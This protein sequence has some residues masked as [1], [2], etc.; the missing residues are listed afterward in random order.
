MNYERWSLP[1]RIEV[2]PAGLIVKHRRYDW[3]R[4]GQQ[5]KKKMIPWHEAQLFAIRSGK[6]GGATI[7]YELSSP[8]TVLTFDRILRPRWWSRFQPAPSFG[9]Y[10]MQMEALL[11]LICA[12][13]GLRLYDVREPG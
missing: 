9:E 11:S 4:N 12:H 7:R 1:Q 8:T 6:P 5:G 10:N 2:T 13:T 3:A